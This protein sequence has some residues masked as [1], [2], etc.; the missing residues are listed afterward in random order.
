MESKAQTVGYRYKLGMHMI[1]AHGPVDALREI[2]VDD[3]QAWA[4]VSTGG[5]IDIDKPDLFGGDQREGGISG[6]VDVEMG[7]PSQAA[8]DYLE[9]VK[10][11]DEPGYRGVLGLVL[12]QCYLGNNP[13]LKP[14]AAR[15]TRILTAQGGAEQWYPE[16]AP[17][18]VGAVGGGSAIGED[19]ALVAGDQ[20]GVLRAVGISD[21][22][23]LWEY[24]PSGAATV[25]DVAF[26]GDN[27]VYA[28]WADGRIAKV[29]PG[30][31]EEWAVGAAHTS[32]VT[33][34]RLGAD[35]R[36]FTAGLDGYLRAWD[37][38]TGAMDWEYDAGV[39]IRRMDLDA[40]HAYLG[41]Y[42]AFSDTAFLRVR[43]VEIDAG[44]VWEHTLATFGL[45]LGADGSGGAYALCGNTG[46]LV[47]L[48]AAGTQDWATGTI[49]GRTGNAFGVDAEG[50]AWFADDNNVWAYRASGGLDA[51][52]ATSRGILADALAFDASGDVWIG[53]DTVVRRYTV[54]GAL[55]SELPAD[56]GWGDTAR[57]ALSE[58]GE[59]ATDYGPDMNPAHIIREC[60]TNSDWGLGYAD[61]DMGDSFT[62]A[63]DALYDEQLGMSLIWQSAVELEEFIGEIL[64]HIDAVLYVDRRTGKFELR[65]IRD[66]YTVGAL[67][68]FDEGNVVDWG[69]L[70][71]REQ[72]DLVNQVTV[73]YA[74]VLSDKAG[75]RTLADTALVA[76]LGQVIPQTIDY[77]GIRWESLAVRL[78]A[79]DLRALSAPLFS[80]EIRVNREGDS[81]SPGD[82][83]ILRSTRRN[84]DDVVMRVVELDHGDGRDNAIRLKLVQDVFALGAAALAGGTTAADIPGAI[85]SAPAALTRRHVAEAP[86]WL[87]VAEL[88]H[89]AADDALAAEP[90]GGALVLAGNRPSQDA[91]SAE[92][93]TETAGVYGRDG[94][95]EFVPTAVLTAA[96][97]ADPADTVLSVGSWT[98]YAEAADCI[99]LIAD[100]GGELVRID[101]VSATTVTVGRGVLDTVPAAHA[102]GTA[103]VIWGL[104]PATNETGFLAGDA[105]GVRLL[106]WTG[107]GALALAAAPIDTVTFDSRAIRPLPPGAFTV[108]GSYTPGEG[109]AVA[110][111]LAL[112]WAHRDRTAQTSAVLDA[113]TAGDIG[114]EAGVSYEL[115]F[116]W[117]DPVTEAPGAVAHT[118]A[119]GT[120]TSY[121]LTAA[122]WPSP[123]SSPPETK[124]W[125]RVR[126]K[127]TVG[128]ETYYSW[129][130][131]AYLMR[132]PNAAGADGFL[133]ETEAGAI[134]LETGDSL[135]RE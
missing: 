84:L 45:A 76:A 112:A 27:N 12:R 50:R 58:G 48:T 133:L 94:T 116:R 17:I 5:R 46:P 69:G 26:D 47:H 30:G 91:F 128:S 42:P 77:P 81:L 39:G 108:N 6:A 125:L 44:Q 87:A 80:G 99:G 22:A 25:V 14:W 56:S 41:T 16:K 35:G 8:N 1:L 75:A 24:D 83:I 102:S 101:A 86:Y 82:A 61:A 70:G 29:S 131:R 63:A 49:F 132:D 103:L 13:Y 79:R 130:A 54:G 98:S 100:L 109:A 23:V 33:G 18:Y 127:R 59:P 111:D 119:L 107:Q 74:E 32:A 9:A 115:D 36:L 129:T 28:G 124:A 34:V 135:L 113:Y 57:I 92:V 7:G 2:R 52:F 67:P 66:D 97:S 31:V 20:F 106:P 19:T 89:S 4:G 60:L 105:V 62:D 21:N 110:G 37:A 11:Q 134:L 120:A 117:A 90:D 88:G 122:S 121:T 114:P 123:P 118:I 3:R 38:A 53:W 71:R 72:A 95:A 104:R 10:G 85:T 43:K 126:A 78:A 64:R 73:T 55:V 96:V 15:I 93:W 68:V 65:L 40:D 51:N